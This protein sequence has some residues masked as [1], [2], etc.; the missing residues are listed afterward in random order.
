VGIGLEYASD[1]YVDNNTVVVQTYWAPMEYRF[2]GSSSLVFR[3]NLVNRP[4]QRRDHAP[5]AV[6]LN[7]LEHIEPS[8][9]RDLNT[10]DLRLTAAAK[11]AVDH[12]ITL[13]D[14]RD[15]VD[16]RPRP[17]GAGWDIG[18]CEFDQGGRQRFDPT[19]GFGASASP[20][21]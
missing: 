6:Q 14:F 15:D 8:W 10:G 5:R 3:N 1:V 4:I 19:T 13:D 9:F 7:N 11:P 21:R 18:A 2:E 12:G 20:L 17:R 16:G